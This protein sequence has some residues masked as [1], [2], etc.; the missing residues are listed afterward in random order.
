MVMVMV[1]VMVMTMMMMVQHYSF[2][3]CCAWNLQSQSLN[4]NCRPCV[5]QSACR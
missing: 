1:M 4:M 3:L 2:L 5:Y